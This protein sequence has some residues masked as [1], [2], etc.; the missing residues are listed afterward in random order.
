[1]SGPGTLVGRLRILRDLAVLGHAPASM[2]QEG[3]ARIDRYR[4]R[5]DLDW[6]REQGWAEQVV[7]PTPHE[8]RCTEEGRERLE[9]ET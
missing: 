5:C 6:L 1:M 3:G 7:G 8:W 2:L 4:T 9:G